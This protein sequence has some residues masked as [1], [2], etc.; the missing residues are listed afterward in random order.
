MR[1]GIFDPYLDDLGGGEKYMMTIASC[2][3]KQHD[4]DVFWDNNSDLDN[5]IHRFSLDLSK[6]KIVPNIFSSKTPFLKRF[7]KTRHY[8]LIIFLSDGSIPIISC[9]LL[10]H[11]QQPLE[12]MQARSLWDKVKLS[13]I[14]SFFC[15]SM[16]TRS[17]IDKKFSLKTTVLYPPVLFQPKQIKKENIILHVGRFRVRNVS[18]NDYKK[19]GVMINKFKE[20]VKNGLNNWEFVLA[21]SI[22]EKDA[23]EFE[24]MKKSAQGFPIRFLINQTNDKLWEIYSKAKIYWHATGFGEDLNKRPELAEHFGISTVEA[25]GAGAVPVVINEGGQR[26]IGEN[27]KNGFLWNSLD[28]LEEKTLMLINNEKLL[29]QLSKIAYESSK[30]FSEDNFCQKVNEL[31]K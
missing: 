14:Q 7:I 21:V 27:G 30:R 24:K 18:A 4:V 5:L 17:F 28:E 8:D 3:S 19:Q 25:M 1:I 15:N 22:Q 29:Q 20:M 31:I 10:V 11:I 2:L 16:Y 13:R 6:I 9:K 12:Q 26:E 23:L